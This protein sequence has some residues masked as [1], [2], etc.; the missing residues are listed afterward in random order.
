M[1]TD[2]R[3]DARALRAS[4]L[5]VREVAARVGVAQSSASK[6][7][8]DIALTPEQ[9]RAL[10]ERGERGRDVARIRKANDARAVRRSYQEEGRRLARNR[11]PLYAAGCILYWA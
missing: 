11:G 1:K 10:D 2:E 9:R 6:W 3:R 4:G 8:R 5:S 7:V